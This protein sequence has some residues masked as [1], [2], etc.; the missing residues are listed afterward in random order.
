[1]Q[2]IWQARG[3]G[4]YAC[5]FVVTFFWLEAKM[6][7]DDIAAAAGIGDYLTGQLVEKL[8]RYFGES[9]VNGLLAVIWPV[10]LIDFRPPWGIAILAGGYVVFTYLL[11]KPIEA[12]L[13]AGDAVTSHDEAARDG[14]SLPREPER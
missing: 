10:F 3:G 2:A 8:F 13:F 12:W 7:V 14:P 6:F 11:R 5:G 4:F 9:F 1:M